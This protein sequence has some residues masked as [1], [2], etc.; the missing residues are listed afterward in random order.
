MRPAASRSTRPK[1][2]RQTCRGCTSPASSPLGSTPIRSSSRTGAS[3]VGGS[4]TTSK[5][6]PPEL[7]LGGDRL[8]DIVRPRTRC[9]RD[10]AFVLRCPAPPPSLACA[11]EAAIHCAIGKQEGCPHTND[12]AGVTY[13]K[14]C[15]RPCAV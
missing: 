15:L 2:W 4:A 6:N 13:R 12:N 10:E 8:L 7:P 1:R 11:L 9:E 14:A 5:A 3:T